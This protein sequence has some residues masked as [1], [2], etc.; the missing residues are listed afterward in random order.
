MVILNLVLI[1]ILA[2]HSALRNLAAE[3]VKYRVEQVLA[4]FMALAGLGLLLKS[5][6]LW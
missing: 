5:V 1:I 4:V 2:A 3:Y 6:N